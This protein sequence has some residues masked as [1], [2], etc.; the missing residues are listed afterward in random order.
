MHFCAFRYGRDEF[1]PYE[2]YATGLAR[3]IPI[4]RLR[5]EFIDFLLHYR[6][7][8][9][10]QALGIELSKPLPLWWLPWRA[11]RV[12]GDTTA[13]RKS[14]EEVP[15]L[16]TYFCEEGIPRARIEQEFFWLER[17]HARIRDQGY[18]PRRHGFIRCLELSEG[19]S[20]RYLVTDGNHRLAALHGLGSTRVSVEVGRFNPVRLERRANWPLVKQG[21]VGADDA[22]AVFQAYRR[23]NRQPYREH[24]PA[25]LLP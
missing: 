19:E 2:Q 16:L 13:W 10:G 3:G 15:D 22:H 6:P 14:P 12:T 23:G 21:S 1:N 4:T 9:L 20:K 25:R 11:A 24:V 18:R 8:H 7:K 17:A 5:N